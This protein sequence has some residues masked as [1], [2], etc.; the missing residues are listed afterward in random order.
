MD[1]YA[2]KTAAI[3]SAEMRPVAGD[4][5]IALQTNCRDE[6]RPILF[7]DCQRRFDR[8][9]DE[10]GGGQAHAREEGIQY[11]DGFGRLRQQITPRLLDHIAICPTFVPRL[12][13]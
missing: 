1:S 13:Q 7:G 5:D 4:K 8:L 2:A 11:L 6:D 12:D 9:G 10:M 3:E